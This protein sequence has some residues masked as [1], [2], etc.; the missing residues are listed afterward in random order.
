MLEVELLVVDWA[1]RRG[2]SGQRCFHLRKN[3]FRFR[4]FSKKAEGAAD[5]CKSLR[6]RSCVGRCIKNQR[7]CSDCGVRAKLPCKLIPV[8][9]GHLEVGNYDI[10]ML[11]S[12]NVE[13]FRAIAGF[14]QS[15]SLVAEERY[16]HLPTGEI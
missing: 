16:E 4:W 3:H 6:F 2:R 8:H 10:G 5:I 15:V 12:G 1:Q 7:S 13:R 14:Q 11:C 9:Y